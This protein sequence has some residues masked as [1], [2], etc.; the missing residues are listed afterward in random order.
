M[1]SKDVPVPACEIVQSKHPMNSPKYQTDFILG[2]Q[3]MM[4]VVDEIIEDRADDH[5]SQR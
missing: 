1:R 3:F 4:E 5:D 2:K